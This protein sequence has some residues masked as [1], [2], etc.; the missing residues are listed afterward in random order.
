MDLKRGIG[1]VALKKPMAIE[2][3]MVVF[4]KGEIRID[5]TGS[6]GNP[7]VIV[8]NVEYIE[9]AKDKILFIPMEN[10]TG[11]SFDSILW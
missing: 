6:F 7:Y 10:I 4:L 11:I 2:G 8:K 1:T 3:R 5:Y 9:Q